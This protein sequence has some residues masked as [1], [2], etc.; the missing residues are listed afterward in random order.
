MI[1]NKYKVINNLNIEIKNSCVFKNRF[2]KGF[3]FLKIINYIN[4]MQK[5]PLLRFL[6]RI[7]PFT[8]TLLVIFLFFLEFFILILTL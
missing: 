1:Y 8:F 7:G 4:L 2:Y 3:N 6:Y 5:H